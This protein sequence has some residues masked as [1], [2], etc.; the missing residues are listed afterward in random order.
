MGT[1]NVEGIKANHLIINSELEGMDLLLLQEHWLYAFEKDQMNTLLKGWENEIRSVDDEDHISPAARP[2]GHG[3][4]AV[5]WR[6]WLNPHITR[7]DEGNTRVLPML[8]EH[9]DSKVCLIN[10]YLPS[11]NAPSAITRFEEDISLLHTIVRK[12]ISTHTVLLAGDL[13]ADLFNRKTRKEV[14]LQSLIDDTG[15]TNANSKISHLFTFHHKSHQGSKSHLDYLLCSGP[16]VIQNLNVIQNCPVNGSAHDPVLATLAGEKFQPSKPKAIP[17]PP[18]KVKWSEGNPV[19]YKVNLDREIAKFNLDLLNV[20][21]AIVVLNKVI[22]AAEAAA[23]PSISPKQPKG[24][25][26]PYYP[27]LAEAVAASKL[28]HHLWKRAGEPDENHPLSKQRRADSKRVRAVQRRHETEKTHKLYTDIMNSFE[29]DRRVFHKLLKH[30]HGNA[31]PDMALKLEGRLVYDADAQREAWA[32]YYEDLAQSNQQDPDRDLVVEALRWIHSPE[33]DIH[34]VTGEQVAAAV[35]RLNS[36]KAADSEGLQAEHLKFASYT[37]HQCLAVIINKIFASRSIPSMSK[38]GYKLPIPKKG[39]DLLLR[40]NFRGITITALLGKLIEHLLLEIGGPKLKAHIS[41]LQFGFEKGK[42]PTMATL[43][44]TEAAAHSRDSKQNLYVTTLDAVKAFDVVNH[45]ILKQKLHNSGVRGQLWA[46]LDNLYCDCSEVIKWKGELSRKYRVSQGVRQGGIISTALYKEYIN[47]LLIT[48]QQ[49]G[50]GVSIGDIYIGIPTCADDVLLMACSESEMQ[51]MMN[52]ADDYASRHQY[53][54]HPTKSTLTQLIGKAKSSLQL[55]G[56]WHLGKS[57][58]PVSDS[59]EHLGLVWRAGQLCPDIK[60]KIDLAR[61][62][63][64]MLIGHGLHGK[65]GLNPIISAQILNTQVLPRMLYGIEAAVINKKQITDLSGCYRTLLRQY[66]GLPERCAGPAIFILSGTVPAEA[67]LHMRSFTLYGNI[68]RLPEEAPLKRLALRQL[69]EPDSSHS[70]FVYLRELAAIYSINL[71]A[72]CL[73]PWPKEGWKRYIKTTIVGYWRN[74]LLHEATHMTSLCWLDLDMCSSADQ[75]HPLWSTAMYRK[76]QVPKAGIRARLI[77]GTYNLQ[78]KV[79]SYSQKKADPTC[80]LCHQEAEDMPHFL[81][82]CPKLEETRKMQI[83][84][85]TDLL[86]EADCLPQTDEEW[87]R[88]I[89]NG[90]GGVLAK[91]TLSKNNVHNVELDSQEDSYKL[92]ARDINFICNEICYTLHKQRDIL[93]DVLLGG[94]SIK[95]GCP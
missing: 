21:D 19:L 54:L 73:M 37:T 51:A 20:E 90:G 85:L 92:W 11:G 70:W 45:S 84:R 95:G 65:D 83:T 89:L 53:K 93:T 49:A 15:L 42:S 64:Y 81:L 55:Q 9:Q 27:E 13:N 86:I 88:C 82:R 61:R 69:A 17:A 80:M 33:N 29:G 26:K 12:Y 7:L 66:Q 75:P 2:P 5:I 56:S 71:V 60:L 57:P 43:C 8:L 78:A 41:H 38:S 48:M 32:Q 28:S 18:R 35:K 46:L 50:L 14:L 72:A 6:P 74:R 30:K 25:R 59:I 3:G 62:T 76:D 47:D 10:C 87:C 24:P 39:K 63:A 4:V 67:H 52:A 94:G 91:E 16:N 23:F 58:I 44:L 34:E 77:T 36:G 22:L 31:G 1:Y 79:A 40:E 68:C